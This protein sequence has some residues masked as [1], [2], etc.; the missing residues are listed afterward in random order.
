[1]WMSLV[2]CF[3]LPVGLFWFAG[4][5]DGDDG[6]RTHWIV[7]IVASS[8]FG[9]GIFVVVL[10]VLNF[11]VDSYGAYA[12]S[13]LAGVIL[14]RNV[15]GAVFPLFAESMYKRL[16]YLGAGCLLGA[17]ALVFCAVPFMFYFWGERIR[18]K[19]HFA[20][21]SAAGERVE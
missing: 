19:S 7:P 8:L 2:A 12:A 15:V 5:S 1:M 20:R 13:S 16:G 11:V 3:L 6:P 21:R 10:G 18:A 17:L 4:C 14:V 9:A